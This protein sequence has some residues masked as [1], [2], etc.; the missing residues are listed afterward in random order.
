MLQNLLSKKL[1]GV[2]GSMGAIA[3]IASLVAS[4]GL[5]APVGLAFG[6]MALLAGVTQN[7]VQGRIDKAKAGK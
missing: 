7:I 3:F 4:G 2:Y 1:F 5:T 6:G